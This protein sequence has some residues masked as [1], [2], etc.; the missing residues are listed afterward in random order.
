MIGVFDS[1][2][3][4]LSVL[5]PLL[6]MAPRANF[7]YFGDTGHVPYGEREP[8]EIIDLAFAI[9]DFLEEHQVQLILVA[10]NTSSA[11]ALEKL[12]QHS[13]T[14]IYGVIESGVRAA[15]EHSRE[16]QI[17]VLCNQVTHDNKG[18]QS[19]LK[20]YP[21]DEHQ[22]K[23]MSTPCPQLVPLIEKAKHTQAETEKV[24][25]GYLKASQ[26]NSCDQLILGCTHYPFIRPWIER[27]WPEVHLIDPG[28]ALASFI[29]RH[30][31]HLLHGTSSGTYYVSGESESFLQS[32][33]QLYPSLVTE[34]TQ[35]YPVTLEQG[36]FRPKD[37]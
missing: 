30:Y 7:I 19:A 5:Q 29:F 16:G 1:G 34:Q 37:L 2:V 23:M 9:T 14:P 25:E 32:A 4:G 13:N 27:L 28:Y 36:V 21:S 26:A 3:G 15:L 6:K 11:L 18:Y 35:C 8:E 20:L 17:G 12:R 31:Q 24:V 22:L 10:C 33:R